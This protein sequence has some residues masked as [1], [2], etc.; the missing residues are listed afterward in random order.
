MNKLE[1]LIKRSVCV[2]I[3]TLMSAAGVLIIFPATPASAA[4]VTMVEYESNPVYDPPVTSYN[5]FYPCVLYDADGFSGHGASYYYKMWYGDGAG[6]L[7]TVT[8]SNDGINWNTPVSTSGL[9]TNA[10]HSQVVYIPGGYDWEGTTYYYKIWY[11]DCVGADLYSV[12]AIRTADSTDGVSWEKDRALTQDAG[13]PI[14]TGVSPDWNRGSYGPVCILHNPDATNTGTN[15][16]DYSFAMY[17]DGTTGGAEVMGLGY[18]AD[19]T[20]FY[21]Y[22][23]D[24]VLGSGPLGAWDGPNPAYPGNWYNTAGT[25]IRGEDGTWRM[26]YSAWQR[27]D[28]PV[29]FSNYGIGYAT[30]TDGINWTRDADNPIFFITDGKAWRDKRTYTPSVIN[31]PTN[32]DGHGEAASYKMWFTGQTG[33]AGEDSA[34]GYASSAEPS[35]SL[36]KSATPS[37]TLDRGQTVTYTLEAENTGNLVATGCSI[38]DSLP[39]YTDYIAG[40]TTLNG[41]AVPDAGGTTP[42]VSG[43]S[44]GS[45]GQ[46]AGTIGVSKKAVVTFRVQLSAD[47]PQGSPVKNTATLSSVGSSPVEASCVNPS[48]PSAPGSS[49]YFAEGYTGEGFQEYLCVG[50]PNEDPATVNVDYLFTDGTV[51]SAVYEVPGQSRFTVDVNEAVGDGREVSMRLESISSKLIAERPMY[52]NYN[53]TWSGGH[54]VIGATTAGQQWYFA[55]GYTGPGFEEYACVLNPGDAPAGLTFNFQT[56]ESGEVVKTGYSVPAHSRSTFKIN[57]VLGSDRQSSL[58][59]DSDHPVVAERP[60]YFEYSGPGGYKSWTGGH[61]VMGAQSLSREYHFAEGTTR[62]VPED[63][64]FQAWL[65]LQNPNPDTITVGAIYQLGEGQGENVLRTYTVDPG[66]RSTVYIPDEVGLNKDVSITLES[67]S[68]FLAER[69]MYFNYRGRWAGGHCIIGVPAAGT[70]WYLAEGYTGPGFEE[71]LTLQNPGDENATVQITYFSQESVASE[72]K[73]VTVPAG[74]RKT[75]YVN[76]SAGA[77]LQ[78]STG[79][80]S[81]KPV[82]VERPMYFSFNGVWNGGH[83]VSG[84]SI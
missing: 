27:I 20:H 48:R 63:G 57:D 11:W 77:N 65:T 3:I 84:Q 50:N 59:I 52:F 34:I 74:T 38:K 25:V 23:D 31:S 37:G 41:T 44:V 2:L 17:Y 24:P 78:L 61:C 45:A 76:D 68:E 39:A 1:V 81:D 9:V 18:S 60:M 5:E 22:G 66:R 54:D 55:E 62:S 72:T 33:T 13:S 6:D 58:R 71:W 51:E 46:P 43:M 40:S 35:L 42:L 30:S 82:V 19:G 8:C 36:T 70:A 53:G 75:L 28:P 73:T 16:F 83:V 69:P 56:L 64:E 80:L 26:W 67:G 7:V 14:I 4:D 79:I 49:F 29:L 15:P 32:F 10:Y 47:L 21:R 12:N